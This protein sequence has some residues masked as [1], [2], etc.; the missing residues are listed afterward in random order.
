MTSLDM[1]MDVDRLLASGAVLGAGCVRAG[2]SLEEAEFGFRRA[3]ALHQ[4]A[5]M[6]NADLMEAKAALAKEGTED[7]IARL[8]AIQMAIRSMELEEAALAD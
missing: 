5:R 2:A 8:Q 4:Q 1:N 6:L 3:S 7:N